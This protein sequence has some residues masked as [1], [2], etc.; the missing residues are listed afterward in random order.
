MTTKDEVD[1]YRHYGKK[2]RQKYQ[3]PESIPEAFS[4]FGAKWIR[5]E[6][7]NSKK[8]IL[9]YNLYLENKR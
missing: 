6:K 7:Q 3:P 4:G 5:N 8:I 2:F 9:H 1:S